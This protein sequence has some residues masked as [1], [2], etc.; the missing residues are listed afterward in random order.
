MSQ[1]QYLNYSGN[2]S[3]YTYEDSEDSGFDVSF[4]SESTDLTDDLL[5]YDDNFINRKNK[6]RFTDPNSN[7]LYEK[8]N[9]AFQKSLNESES[10]YYKTSSSYFTNEHS[11]LYEENLSETEFCNSSQFIKTSTPVKNKSEHKNSYKETKTK[12]RYATGRNRVSRAKSPSQVQKIKRCR[13]MKANDRERNRMHILNEALERLRCVL[14]TF[15]EDTKLTKIETLRFAHSYIWALSQTV[16]NVDKYY[17]EGNQSVV[18]N[19]GNVTVSINRDGNTIT[20]KTCDQNVPNGIVTHGTITNAS[21]MQ[22]TDFEIKSESSSSFWADEP[23]NEFSG[24]N[25]QTV[26]YPVPYSY[27]HKIQCHNNLDLT[28]QCI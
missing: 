14:P 6:P 26:P 5:E 4:K 28:Y 24:P 12:R 17:T 15:P 7:Q 3:F 2:R 20:S 19:V 16:N 21:F 9:T 25:Y 27:D 23:N 10:K 1:T 18:I 13:R 11:N 22:D 8:F